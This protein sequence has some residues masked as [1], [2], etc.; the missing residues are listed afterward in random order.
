M[1]LALHYWMGGA[2]SLLRA[3]HL[4]NDLY[5]VEWDVKPYHTIIVHLWCRTNTPVMPSPAAA[6][7]CCCVWLQ[8]AE[9]RHAVLP[10]PWVRASRCL[11]PMPVVCRV[12]LCSGLTRMG[13]PH[14][15]LVA[16]GMQE[17]DYVT[18]QN[19]SVLLSAWQLML[20]IPTWVM[21]PMIIFITGYRITGDRV[22]TLFI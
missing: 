10:L 21:K 13:L 1:S 19:T 5:Y 7:F 11:P 9:C 8:S 18:S 4:R 16:G 2:T 14:C 17:N 22:T 15:C 3:P 12:C 20:E 6:V